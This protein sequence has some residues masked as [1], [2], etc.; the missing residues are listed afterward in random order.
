MKKNNLIWEN[1]YSKNKNNKYPW[2]SIVSFVF[3]HKPKNKLNSNIKI[4][5]VGCGSGSNLWFAARE[6]F[7]V[8]GID[9]SSNAIK[10]AKKRFK[11]DG[12]NG[13]FKVGDFSELPY[14]NNSFDLII[15]RASITC[16]SFLDAKKTISE[17][18]RVLKVGGKF[19]FTPYS[20]NH[21]SFKDSKNKKNDLVL[22]IKHGPISNVGQISFYN[23]KD[24]ISA[25][26]KWEIL[27]ISH[28]L[29]KDLTEKK[30]H[31]SWEVIVKKVRD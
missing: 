23:K 7:K 2:D 13:D 4:L 15:D 16:V 12:L 31:A 8:N 3:N 28:I 6:K 29:R 19:L 17:I 14:L 1:I 18:N 5:E 26:K 27:S 20:K 11:K 25:F 24:I 9:F 10:F 21:Y 22:N 30:E